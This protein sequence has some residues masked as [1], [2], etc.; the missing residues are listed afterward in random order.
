M[1]GTLYAALALHSYILSLVCCCLQVRSSLS[2]HS[3]KKQIIL[4]FVESPSEGMFTVIISRFLT[5]LACTQC[6]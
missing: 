5:I 6:G 2:V 3:H 1:A 4:Q